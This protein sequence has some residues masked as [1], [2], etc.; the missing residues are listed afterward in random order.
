MKNLH[1][2]SKLFVA[3]SLLLTFSHH[4]VVEGRDKHKSLNEP[5][6]S[7]F[8]NLNHSPCV[9][10]YHRAGRVGCGTVDRETQTGPIYY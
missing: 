5:F 1:P 6:Q 3:W 9:T 4:F 2:G 7:S 10:L 8:H